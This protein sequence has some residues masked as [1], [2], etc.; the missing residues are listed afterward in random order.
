MHHSLAAYK[1]DQPRLA[2]RRLPN[3]IVSTHGD[4]RVSCQTL[5]QRV[6]APDLVWSLPTGR[7]GLMISSRFRLS[8][9]PVQTRNDRFQFHHRGQLHFKVVSLIHANFFFSSSDGGEVAFLIRDCR[10]LRKLAF[11][12]S[13]LTYEGGH[14][15]FSQAAKTGSISTWLRTFTKVQN[16][17][18]VSET[19]SEQNGYN[20][21]RAAV[22]TANTALVR[23]L[24]GRH[25]QM[26]AIGGSIGECMENE[27]WVSTLT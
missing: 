26:I 9:Y 13:M 6:I 23:Q 15:G 12:N 21:R 20:V 8:V 17:E 24:K 11:T 14:L 22:Q 7:V 3:L 4:K 2:L 5:M 18:I 25:L 27:V 16:D 1:E 19:A 10:I